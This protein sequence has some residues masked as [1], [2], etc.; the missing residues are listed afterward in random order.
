MQMKKRGALRRKLR[1]S[2]R[3]KSCADRF[4]VVGDQTR[5]KICY[6][7]CRHPELAVSDIAQILNAP[8]STVS[9]SLKQLKRI[10]AVV[11]RRREKQIFYGLSQDPFTQVLR[12]Q[13]LD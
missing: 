1:D 6:L 11:N 5:L 12:S 4:G 10:H 7:L 8:I 13:L 2:T 9:H 3:I